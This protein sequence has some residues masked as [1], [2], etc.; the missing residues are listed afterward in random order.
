MD[1]WGTLAQ[2]KMIWQRREV[3]LEEERRRMINQRRTKGHHTPYVPE[4]PP[5]RAKMTP[6][7]LAERMEKMRVQNDKGA[8]NM[9]AD[10]EAFNT[11]VAA[12]R[13]RQA[14]NRKVQVQIDQNGNRMRRAKANPPSAQAR[15]EA[16]NIPQVNLFCCGRANK[17]LSH[18]DDPDVTSKTK[19]DDFYS[20]DPQDVAKQD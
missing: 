9:K 10:E 5:V 11:S 13:A 16:D 6:E 3:G 14:A 20:P 15:K 8:A 12:D 18:D 2:R 19:A 1:S 7:S 17:P 4:T